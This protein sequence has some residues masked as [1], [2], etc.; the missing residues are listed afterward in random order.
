LAPAALATPSWSSEVLKARSAAESRLACTTHT[1]SAFDQIATP[2]HHGAPTRR[3]EM[4]VLEIPCPALAAARGRH[5]SGPGAA[6]AASANASAP[7]AATAASRSSSVSS[8]RSRASAPGASSCPARAGFPPRDRLYCH[9]YNGTVRTGAGW[10][11]PV[12]H[13][14]SGSIP[15]DEHAGARS[16]MSPETGAH[17][18]LPRRPT[19]PAVVTL[20]RAA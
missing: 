1:P 11:R 18:R 17:R 8:H 4:T 10:P 14:R 7:S 3:D 9:W 16:P 20:R 13:P 5:A 15:P 2:P 12:R 19:A 6:T